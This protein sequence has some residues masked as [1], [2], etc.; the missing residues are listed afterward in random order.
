MC[1][2]H[3]TPEECKNTAITRHFG[4]VFEE[5][6]GLGNHMIFVTPV[7][8]DYRVARWHLTVILFLCKVQ[9]TDYLILDLFLSI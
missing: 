6:L 1:A 4:T 5:K 3:T 2:V 9:E 8:F 7:R